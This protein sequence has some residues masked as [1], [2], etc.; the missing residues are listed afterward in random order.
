M[1][2]Y[3]IIFECE[4]SSSKKNF[5]KLQF[6]F[7]FLRYITLFCNFVFNEYQFINHI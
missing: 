5:Q 6:C 7:I 1:Y 4:I 2:I 3:I